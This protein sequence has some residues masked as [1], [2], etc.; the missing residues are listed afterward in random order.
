M[1]VLLSKELVRCIVLFWREYKSMRAT[2]LSIERNVSDVDSL[3]VGCYYQRG[4]CIAVFLKHGQRHAT[5]WYATGFISGMKTRLCCVRSHRN[6]DAIV[7]CCVET[8]QRALIDVRCRSLSPSA[9]PPSSPPLDDRLERSRLEV[10]TIRRIM[11]A[12]LY[13]DRSYSLLPDEVG[14][15]FWAFEHTTSKVISPF[16]SG[17][18]V[19]PNNCTIVQPR[20]GYLPLRKNP[21][22]S[23][24]STQYC[25]S[26]PLPRR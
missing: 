22:T 19:A 5:I 26:I 15:F 13:R 24:P 14:G 25:T 4:T 8:D 12:K 7:L 23:A 2:I 3:S 20:S 9:R 17:R 10:M 6:H 21:T 16:H 18:I 1:R 11:D